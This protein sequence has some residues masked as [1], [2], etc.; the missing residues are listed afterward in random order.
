MPVVPDISPEEA[1]IFIA[2]DSQVKIHEI[3]TSL[4]RVGLDQIVEIATTYDSAM[5]FVSRQEPGSLEANVMLLDGQLDPALPKVF[6]CGKA[7]LGV[8]GTKF[9]QAAQADGVTG[10]TEIVERMHREVLFVGTS[11]DTEG[12][13][14]QFAQIPL[15][16][17]EE[18]AG[19]EVYEML[20]GEPTTPSD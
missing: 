2:D 16:S 15:V 6:D 3:R 13:L 11:G 12:T 9:T 4:A 10:M 18:H 8:I 14:G 17:D 7:L 19:E 20:F 1:R 5:D